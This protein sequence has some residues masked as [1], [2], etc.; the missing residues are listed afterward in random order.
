MPACHGCTAHTRAEDYRYHQFRPSSEES[1]DRPPTSHDPQT[2]FF[3]IERTAENLAPHLEFSARFH[4]PQPSSATDALARRPIENQTVQAERGTICEDL[5]IGDR[6]AIVVRPKT[7]QPFPP[8]RP[9]WEDYCDAHTNIRK[10]EH[11]SARE[12]DQQAQGNRAAT[13]VTQH[14][15][16]YLTIARR[17]REGFW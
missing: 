14:S 3:H 10:L 2:E 11:A 4:P 15:K 9:W 7:L 13:A 8:L 12:A 5:S 6:S 1:Y 17:G 16:E